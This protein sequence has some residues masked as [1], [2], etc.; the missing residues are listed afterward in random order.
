MCV[1]V[2]VCLCLHP[3]LVSSFLLSASPT[4]C[5]PGQQTHFLKT[6]MRQREKSP[7]IPRGRHFLSTPRPPPPPQAGVG[8]ATPVL[9]SRALHSGHPGGPGHGWPLPSSTRSPREAGKEALQRKQVLPQQQVISLQEDQGLVG[10]Q[11]VAGTGGRPCSVIPAGS[12]P[13]RQR[14]P[15]PEVPPDIQVSEEETE[16]QRSL[17][18]AL[19]GDPGTLDQK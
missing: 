7:R 11:S 16:V 10:L 17:E 18:G 3:A 15:L 9:S 12:C 13:S 4:P 2:R 14:L 6:Q 1:C 19:Q 8:Q 5:S